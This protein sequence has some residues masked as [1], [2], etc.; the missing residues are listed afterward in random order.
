MCRLD[1]KRVLVFTPRDV[2]NQIFINIANEKRG[3]NAASQL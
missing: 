3:K 2:R 1:M